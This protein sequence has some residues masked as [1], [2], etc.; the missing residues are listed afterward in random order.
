MTA[1]S[2]G[3]EYSRAYD[4]LYADKDYVQ[5][6]DVI[7]ELF[8]RH[9]SG[10]IASILDLGC[11]TGGHS[12]V[13]A[14]RGYCVTG[15]D[16]SKEMIRIAKRKVDSPKNAPAFRVGDA[17]TCVLDHKYDAVIMMFA[18]LGYQHTNEDVCATLSTV[19]R[20][21]NAGGVFI[22]DVWYGPAVLAIR[23]NERSRTLETEGGML[24]RTATATIDSVHHTADVHYRIQ[25]YEG[26]RMVHKSQE[27]HRVRYFFREEL[28]IYLSDAEMTLSGI[29]DCKHLQSP[30]TED[31]WSILVAATAR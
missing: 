8:R 11:G 25:R 22:C 9:G 10:R 5:E 21:L 31:S 13:L 15:V 26:P 27:M 1:M 20:H 24:V 28:D 19:R 2:F 17:R 18:V 3:R 4:L 29:A 23:P 30:P 12:L 7:E 16:L 6:C 14:Q